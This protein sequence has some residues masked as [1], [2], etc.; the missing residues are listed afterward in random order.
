MW[1]L[2]IVQLITHLKHKKMR[3]LEITSEQVNNYYKQLN[4][5]FD[6]RVKELYRLNYKWDSKYKRYV[7]E[8]DILGAEN[9]RGF[10]NATLMHCDEFHFQ[11]HK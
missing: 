3:N 9:N 1:Y 2:A 7:K 10:N 4:E 8:D 11:L 6:E 5:R